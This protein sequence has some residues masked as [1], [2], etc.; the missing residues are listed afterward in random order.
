MYAPP[1]PGHKG[2]S[3]CFTA[4]PSGKSTTRGQSTFY[5]RQRSVELVVCDGF[6]Q[7]ATAKFTVT[8]GMACALLTRTIPRKY[9]HVAL[10]ID[11]SCSGAAL[12]AHPDVETDL[13][14]ACGFTADLLG[15]PL[16]VAG[17][18]AGLACTLAPAVGHSLADWAESHHERAIARNVI[19]HGKCIRF[20]RHVFTR[21]AA[22]KCDRHDPG[23]RSL[24]KHRALRRAKPQHARW[25]SLDGT[26]LA[27]NDTALLT[28]E[29][30]LGS[31]FTHLWSIGTRSGATVVID[32]SKGIPGG[33]TSAV[34]GALVTAPSSGH[35]YGLA[36]VLLGVSFPQNGINPPYS[37][38][39][40]SVFDAQSGKHLATSAPFDA[41]GT[42]VAYINGAVR[43][44]GGDFATVDQAGHVSQAQL[45]GTGSFVVSPPVSGRVLVEGYAQP[46][47]GCP[48]V[49]VVDVATEATVSQSPCIHDIYNRNYSNFYFDGL[50]FGVP[51]AS[52]FF[53]A[54]TAQP[55][56]PPGQLG[57]DAFETGTETAG[58]LNPGP[59]SD[60]TVVQNGASGYSY[61]IST[62]TWQTVFTATPSQTF[63][64]LGVADDDVWVDTSHWEG[65]DYPGGPIVIDG[66]N[67]HEVA[68]GWTVYPVAGGAGW[69]LASAREVCCS[70]EYLLRSSGTLLASLRSAPN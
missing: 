66:H 60:L 10:F 58:F 25:I 19:R 47:D 56:T 52:R 62:T 26:V 49:F 18:L 1:R 53:L 70:R 20:N 22:V 61:V 50:A 29:N 7:R 33:T 31:A 57:P 32:L 4:F 51:N 68:S 38:A 48:T 63:N 40:F 12:A 3:P 24:R 34:D 36:V 2:P 27:H 23:F 9:R 17:S 5:N 21:W 14:A 8:A 44:A 43:L 13:G 37:H 59:R 65:V 46:S 41:G 45:P 28:A 64:A 69:T 54:A 15:V 11:G 67:G 30:F 6:G 16:K 39:Y 42:P 55:L 35:P